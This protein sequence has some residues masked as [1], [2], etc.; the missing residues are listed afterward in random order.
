[1]PVV[2][3][4]E[5]QEVDAAGQLTNVFEIT[6]TIEGRPGSFTLQVP[7]AGDSVAAARAAIDELT[8]QVNA[9]YGL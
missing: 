9:I 3:I 5:S 8:A 7:R 6:Y 4:S 2:A 1:M